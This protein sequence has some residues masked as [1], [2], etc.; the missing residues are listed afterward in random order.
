MVRCIFKS[1]KSWLLFI[2][3][4]LLTRH[5]KKG[6]VE[7]FVSFSQ[8]LHCLLPSVTPV[9]MLSNGIMFY[10]QDVVLLFTGIND[11]AGSKQWRISTWICRHNS[12]WQESFS[13]VICTWWVLSLTKINAWTEFLP[14]KKLFERVRNATYNWI[15]INRPKILSC[16]GVN[17]GGKH[18]GSWLEMEVWIIESLVRYMHNLILSSN[19]FPALALV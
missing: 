18:V 11:D 4:L 16:A 15:L 6:V 1:I 14:F 3:E 9:Q 8:I 7:S 17:R 5:T 10:T 13:W 19:F 2:A 12:H